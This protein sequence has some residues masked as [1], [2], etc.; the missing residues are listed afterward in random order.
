MKSLP[1][2][3]F[4]FV[5][6]LN[7]NTLNAQIPKVEW[8]NVIGGKDIEVTG[9]ITS[10]KLNNIYNSGE[11]IDTVD[12]D[13]G[14][15]T[16]NLISNTVYSNYVSKYNMNGNFIWAKR[17]GNSIFDAILSITTDS[18]GNFYAAGVFK[19]LTD[20]NLG[21]GVNNLSSN[22]QEAGFIL[23]LDS[24][25]NFVWA[26]KIGA[27]FGSIAR[28][29]K[30]DK[31]QNILISGSFEG[32]GDFN[33]GLGVYNL[34]SS[35]NKDNFILKLNNNG[36]FV[37]AKKI[38][39]AYNDEYC[40]I[41][42]DRNDNVIASGQFY[43]TIDL[44]PSANTSNVSS[45]ISSGLYIV[46]LDMNGNFS[47]GKC[48]NDIGTA[49]KK[50]IAVDSNE[51][52]YISSSFF[53]SVDF[54]PGIGTYSFTTKTNFGILEGFALKLDSNGNFVWA[55]HL[56]VSNSIYLYSMNID[57][58]GDIFIVG[59]YK[60]K[61]KFFS[62]NK[63]DSLFN[64]NSNSHAGYILKL[65]SNG[66]LKWLKQLTGNQTSSFTVNDRAITDVV[67]NKSNEV[68]C[69]GYFNGFSTLNVGLNPNVNNAN[70]SVIIPNANSDVFLFKLSQCYPPTNPNN[71][72]SIQNLNICAGNSTILTAS[73]LGT[74]SW[75]SF[76]GQLIATGSTINT[77]VLNDTTV[78]YVYDS[79]C[80]K[81]L[82]GTKIVVNV[83]DSINKNLSINNT[84][85]SANQIGA[86]YQWYNC[87]TNT[88][89]SG[90]TAQLFTPS[91]NG[92]YSV[93]ITKN[94]CT[95][96]SNCIT[97][98]NIGFDDYDLNSSVSIFPNPTKGEFTIASPLNCIHK[99]VNEI[100]QT[101]KTLEVKANTNNTFDLTDLMNGIYYL[102]GENGIREKIVVVK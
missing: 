88:N 70:S 102:V 56:N 7:F 64:T 27:T 26:K 72:S 50:S 44:D 14:P 28:S 33:L 94:G 32:T 17:F 16:F 42:L 54:D 2:S 10:D 83:S 59:C 55:K 93:I 41:T 38:G 60:G 82:I 35:G 90:Q 5:Q 81:S 49:E 100:G 73:G 40:P 31:N 85:I 47:W 29:I 77:G 86:T 9:F 101:L 21:I 24:N 18:L 34:T 97:Y 66:N 80:S 20:F 8:A 63:T 74:L 19:G 11:F 4:I 43:G 99:I 69:T 39:N 52:V 15:Q 75:Y 36:D 65:S 51:N 95:D 48:I 96:T 67:I 30:I 22:G 53:G 87:S 13:P 92:S 37:W 89:V 79:T 58:A 61:F 68:F 12:F 45:N 6:I 23:K 76:T 62:N 98:S 46:K 57:L 3:F 78:Y 91:Q 1:T 25:G 71:T 84:T